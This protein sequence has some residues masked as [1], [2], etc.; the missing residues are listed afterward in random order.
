M[1]DRVRGAR[2]LATGP[3]PTGMDRDDAL[4]ASTESGTWRDVPMPDASTTPALPPT[5]DERGRLIPLTPEQI[6]QRNA[7]AIAALDDIER[8]EPDDDPAASFEAIARAL[9]AERAAVGAR[10]LFRDLD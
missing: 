3:V 9:N 1:D 5:V 4:S 6:R 2:D 7:L 8:M 10:L